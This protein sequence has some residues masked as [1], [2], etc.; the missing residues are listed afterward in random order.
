MQFPL[1]RPTKRRIALPAPGPHPNPSPCA[2]GEG[3]VVAGSA[4]GP[5]RF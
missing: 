3:L 4:A 5:Y 2:Q 1:S